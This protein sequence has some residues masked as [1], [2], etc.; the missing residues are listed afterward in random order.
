[1]SAEHWQRVRRLL[2]EARELPPTERGAFLTRVC[3]GDAS[4]RAEVESLIAHGKESA[5]LLDR[6][7]DGSTLAEPP[8]SPRVERVGPYRVVREVGRGGMGSVFLAT[9]DDDEFKRQV[10]LKLLHPGMVS[11]DIVRRFR[12]ERQILAGIDH[13][14]VA[15]LYDGGTTDDG[16]PYLVMEYIDGSRLDD[17]CDAHRL[18]IEKRLTLFRKVCSA[19]HFA[20]QN[21][22]IHRDLKPANILVTAEGEPKLLDFGIAK[23]LNPELAASTLG[24]THAD[25][26]LLTPEYAS[27]EQIKGEPITT[28]SDIYALGV[29]LYRLLTGHSPY[30][31]SGLQLHQLARVI[32]E[33]EPT[34]PSA[35]IDEV[36]EAAGAESPLLI[37]A[38]TVAGNRE[39]SPE[40]LRR[41]LRG[42][43]DNIVLRAL[44][45]EAT[46]RY[47]SV[48]Q[49]SEDIRRF[50]AGLPVH[51]RRGTFAYR[52]SKFI[53][54][55]KAPLGALFTL[56]VLLLGFTAF[57]VRER[58]RAESEAA[59][60]NAVVAFLQ[61]TLSSANPFTGEG[62]D[63]TVLA[64]LE[65]A[66]KRIDS[67]FGDQPEI[68]A[69]IQNTIG[70]TYRDLA[71]YDDAEPLIRS[72][73][74]TRRRVLGPE[75]PDIAESMS[76]LAS[77]LTYKGDYE[78]GERL[79]RDALAM[80]RRLHGNEHQD[81]AEAMSDL[82]LVLDYKGE[83]EE[84]ESIHRQ[85]LAMRR[86]LLG[87]E[88]TAVA[89]SLGNLGVLL[90][91]KGEYEEAEVL[92]SEALATTRT[93]LGDAHP[94]TAQALNNLAALREHRGEF[95]SAKSLYRE[96][97]AAWRTAFGD[98][99][100]DVAIG[101]NN[102]GLLLKKTGDLETAETLLREALAMMRKLYPSEHPNVATAL[103]NLAAALDARGDCQAADLAYAEAIAAYDR[104]L[105]ADHWVTAN[106]RSN[107]AY[108]LT[109][110]ERYDEAEKTLLAAHGVLRGE[111]GEQHE[112]TTGAIRRLVK[113]YQAW[114]QPDRAAEY[115]ALLGRTEEGAQ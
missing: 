75:H 38:S 24:T 23:L 91:D 94:R 108:C 59:K 112:R 12:N 73:L 106:A 100:P 114:G 10:A 14:H 9:R 13:P 16:L 85:A 90:D 48:E 44:R 98:D 65:T 86:R 70:A 82:G 61:E 99:H 30:R 27:P 77:L 63:A 51:A 72:A 43:L 105:G 81:V 110:L 57:T 87:N 56:V 111:L 71:R 32:C 58:E 115:G 109:Q 74:D 39:A 2:E 22:V 83:A 92:L 45:K 60:A 50:V 69:V 62:R 34:R 89:E 107:Y 68:E 41:K 37:S 80:R 40:R 6:P 26:R 97:I 96:A 104:A 76:A 78:A 28:G 54:R 35:V 93:L 52:S 11:E 15:K 3:G 7:A 8:S 25:T 55:H 33:T 84:A 36:E 21:L 79:C 29:L 20:H 88:H 17:Y 5:D 67:S 113:L 18:S 47:S 103:S 102:L 49:L 46:E 95:E 101:V 4:L 64:V 42:D 31:L 66:V 53:R 19:V 1:M